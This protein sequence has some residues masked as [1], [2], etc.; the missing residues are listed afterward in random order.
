MLQRLLRMIKCKR[1]YVGK[2]K[3]TS[4][5]K[6]KIYL[7]YKGHRCV[8][9]FNDNFK[10]ESKKQDFIRCMLLDAQAYEYARDVYDFAEEF[11]YGY[12]NL[13]EA[14]KAYRACEMQSIRVHRLFNEQEIDI[15]ST[16]E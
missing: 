2:S 16:I 7:C 12:E 15:L 3:M 4:G 11:G 14:R 1:V 13:A 10:N 9:E 6:Y 5:N 8:F